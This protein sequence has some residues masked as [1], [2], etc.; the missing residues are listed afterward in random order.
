V[1]TLVS[2]RHEHLRNQREGLRRSI[3]HADLHV[4]VPMDDPE[5]A[6]VLE[7]GPSVPPSC[8]SPVLASGRAGLPLARA[9]N[10]G[11]Q[12]A[13]DAG[14][15]QL[16]FLDVDCVPGPNLLARYSRCLLGG[17]VGLLSGPV[18]HLPPPP[19]AGY[20]L[21]HV[22]AGGWDRSL[23]PVPPDDSL[24]VEPDH[25]LFWSLSF[26]VSRS[27][28]EELGGF[29]ELYEGYGAEDTDFGQIAA[30][31]GVSFAW[32]GGAWAYHQHHPTQNPPVQHLIAILRNAAVFH[33]RWGWWPMTPWLE[34]FA[35]LG[36]AHY[37]TE[38]DEWAYGPKRD[39]PRIGPTCG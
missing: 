29:C 4:V 8:L 21:E 2:G 35:E 17:S 16:V 38:R 19:A 31:K 22:L 14:A 23:R 5:V 3:S 15:D 12:L 30:T 26:A 9:R 1:V 24:V 39:A 32:V 37:D 27:T 11:A 18:A 13:I 33:A 36:L 28:W 25:R 34:Q 7:P 6:G 10:I 20:D